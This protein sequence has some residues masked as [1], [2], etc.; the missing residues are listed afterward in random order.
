MA[1]IVLRMEL[2]ERVLHQ[3]GMDQA[4]AELKK[5]KE[6]T[7]EG[8]ADVRRII[9]DLRPMALDDLGLIPTLNKYIEKLMSN[10]PI[11]IELKM[12]GKE[13]RP[14]PAMEVAVFRLVQEALNNIIKHAQT[15]EAH[16]KLEFQAERIYVIVKDNGIGFDPDKELKSGFGLIG[17]QERVKLLNGHMVVQ[18]SPGNG[19]K[20]LIVL[21]IQK[22]QLEEGINHESNGRSEYSTRR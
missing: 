21:P 1:H 22:D 3:E 11:L 2:V 8:L 20:L 17:M 14:T 12:F 6:S 4:I 16:I 10:H 18:S 9:F 19:T 5:V 13:I 15:R 7:R